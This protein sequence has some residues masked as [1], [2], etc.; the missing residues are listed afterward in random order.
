MTRK[1]TTK[2]L[3]NALYSVSEQNNILDSVHSGL[4]TLN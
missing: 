3:A 2:R 4:N 1:Q